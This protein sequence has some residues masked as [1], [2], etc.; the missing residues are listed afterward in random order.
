M[1]EIEKEEKIELPSNQIKKN[2][3]DK[4]MITFDEFQKLDL[5][6]G[7]IKSAERIPKSKKLLKLTVDLGENRT[8]VAGIAEHYS[9]EELTDKQVLIVAN[10]QPVKLMGVESQ[11][12]VL[13]SIDGSTLRLISPDGCIATGSKVS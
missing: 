5:R 1:N 9:E 2:N 8:I 12:M 11:G 6:I 4:I 3:A 7:T 10:L 13:A